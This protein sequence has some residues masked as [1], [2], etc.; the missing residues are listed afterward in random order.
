M[1]LQL[2]RPIIFFDLE[3]TGT[4]VATDRIVQICYLKVMPSGEEI[5]RTLFI[6][7]EMPI[8]PQATA[9]HHI[10]DADVADKPT[11]K[12]VAQKI[13]T[14]MEG[15]DF[16]GYNSNRF[17]VPLLVEEMLR[18][19]IDFDINKRRFIDVQNIFH[20]KEQRTLSAAYLFYCNKNLEGAHDANADTLATYEVLQAQLDRYPDLQNDVAFLAEY[21][22]MSRNVDPCGAFVYNDKD[23]EVFN[24]GKYKGE[25]VRDVL[26]RDPGY[27]SWMMQGKFALSTKKVITRIRLSMMQGK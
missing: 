18:A 7:P 26:R 24:F 1:K 17:D 10:T 15:C 2:K 9:I 11:F 23:I 25:P 21:S 16:G 22:R 20:K 19:G 6:N 3:T 8:P 14:E 12:Q 27:F 4:N 13:A 5:S